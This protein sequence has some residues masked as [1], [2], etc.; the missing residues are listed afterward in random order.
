MVEGGFELSNL[1]QW[2]VLVLPEHEF[3]LLEAL[4]TL[5]YR[6]RPR[7]KTRHEIS[8][9]RME[10]SIGEQTNDGSDEV[11][12]FAAPI[13]HEQEEELFGHQLPDTW[14]TFPQELE[15]S[16]T[17]I[18]V[19]QEF[20]IE[21]TPRSNYTKSSNDRLAITNPRKWG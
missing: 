10:V 3:E 12:H 5:S 8:L 2:H 20:R 19:K 18:N 14:S 15:I 21:F 4:R 7:E 9:Q 17:F 6:E 1:R 13:E 11:D 16:R